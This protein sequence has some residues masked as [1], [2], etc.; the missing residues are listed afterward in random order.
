MKVAT[1]R[2]LSPVSNLVLAVFAALGL[3][4]TLDLPWFAPLVPDTTDTDGP[5][6]RFAWAVSRTFVHHSGAVD[7]T[8]A[9][10][11]SSWLVFALAGTIAL[12]SAAMAAPVLR[13]ALRDVLR[14]VALATPLLLLVVA[15]RHPGAGAGHWRVHWGLLVALGVGCFA[16][17]AAW[18][19]SQIRTKRAPAGSWAARRP[20]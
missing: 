5:V 18:H 12:L 17:S 10:A 4:T 16:A 1:M 6:E 15:A 7:G 13:R 9:L 3:V 8:R 20:A 14:A 2:Q 11:G 19:G